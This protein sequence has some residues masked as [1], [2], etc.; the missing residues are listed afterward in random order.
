M[1]SN[2]PFMTFGERWPFLK[3]AFPQPNA[4]EAHGKLAANV[5]IVAGQALGFHAA[6]GTWRAPGA[7]VG[8]R[9][10]LA[11]YTVTTDANGNA[12]PG[13]ALPNPAG[14]DTGFET[15]PLYTTGPFFVKDLT[16]IAADADVAEL[17]T[18]NGRAY[19]DAAAV[20][21]LNNA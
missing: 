21:V 1:N 13:T 18:T 4:L 8:P 9:K 20:V 5:T 2:N 15:V 10:R 11:K 12:F 16:G 17:G 3:P 14:S 6:S 19:N 7:G